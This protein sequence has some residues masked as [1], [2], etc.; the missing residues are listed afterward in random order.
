MLDHFKGGNGNNVPLSHI[1]NYTQA[2]KVKSADSASVDQVLSAPF[3]VWVKG[4]TPKAVGDIATIWSHRFG[5]QQQ[6]PDPLQRRR[7]LASGHCR[8]R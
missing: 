4:R 3:T 8:R 7:Q 1:P 2:P 5:R 6:F